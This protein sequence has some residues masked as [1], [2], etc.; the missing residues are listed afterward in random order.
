MFNKYL[1]KLAP[2]FWAV[3]LTLFFNSFLSL[4][5][6]YPYCNNPD[7]G[8]A[9]AAF[10]LPLPYTQFSGVSSME[11][12]FMPLAYIINVIIL[13]LLFYFS[14]RFVLNKVFKHSY[15]IGIGLSVAGSALAILSLIME[16]LMAVSMYAVIVV[17]I[18]DDIY[19]PYTSYRPVGIGTTH[20]DCKPSEFWF[21]AI[22]P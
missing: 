8:P 10:G 21:G 2:V 22:K 12:L 14:T 11:Y 6:S 20:Y 5:W 18:G 1:F 15:I 3:F 13:G 9:Y 19:H 4:E 17:S 7:S 16:L